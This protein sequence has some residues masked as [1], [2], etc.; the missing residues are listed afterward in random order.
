MNIQRLNLIKGAINSLNN[1]SN[2]YLK[3]SGPL[4]EYYRGIS[5]AT[6]FM[7]NLINEQIAAEEA[8]KQGV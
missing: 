4:T 5:K 8:E 3:T 2:E 1:S 6:D 7:M